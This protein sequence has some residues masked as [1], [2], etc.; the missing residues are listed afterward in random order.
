MRHRKKGKKL[1]R[2]RDQRKALHKSL[3]ASFVVNKKMKTT[4]AKAKAIKPIIEKL[5][6]KAKKNDLSARREFLKILT[7]KQAKIMLEEIGPK[8]KDRKGGYLRITKIG[9]RK[10]D[11]AEMAVL[12]LV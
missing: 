3:I 6:T 7:E 2:K 10:G 5:I 1:G 9:P 4:V 8:Y 12:E 11:G